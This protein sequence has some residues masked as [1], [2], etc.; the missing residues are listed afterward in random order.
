MLGRDENMQPEFVDFPNF[1]Q[2]LGF[3]GR[4]F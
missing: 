1:A 3:A 4:N 2:G